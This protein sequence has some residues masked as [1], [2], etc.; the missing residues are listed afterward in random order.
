MNY[1]NKSPKIQII[2]ENPEDQEIAT[3]LSKILNWY[4]VKSK[5]DSHPDCGY[6]MG[7]ILCRNLDDA[8]E[9]IKNSD[10]DD[11]FITDFD[12]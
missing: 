12:V 11:C 3:Q 10:F 7:Q 5:T 2:P 1:E 8:N 6:P 4:V 9:Y